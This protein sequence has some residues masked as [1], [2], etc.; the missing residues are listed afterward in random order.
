MEL[1]QRAEQL[2]SYMVEQRRWF[3]ENPERTGKEDNTI[4][5]I[6]K[7]LDKMPGIEY[8][9]VHNGGIL[10]SI[11]GGKPGKKTIL[12][13]ADV[14]ALPVEETK[15]NLKESGRTCVSKEGGVMHACGHDA[16]MAMQLGAL[17][18]LSD[19]KEEIPG[20][21]HFVFERGE[22]GGGNFIWLLKRVEELG[23]DPDSAWAIHVYADLESGKMAILDGGVMAGSGGI[24]ITIEGSGGHGSRPDQAISP[25]DCFCA[26]YQG[27]ESLRLRRITP[28]KTLTYSIGMLNAGVVGNVIPQTLSFKGSARFYDVE[29]V[30]K[31]FLADLRNLCDHT[32]AAYNCKITYNN[33]SIPGFPV[34]NDLECAQLAREALAKEIG[35]DFPVQPEPWMASESFSLYL[36]MW[37]GVFGLLGIKNPEKGTGAA[38][39]N[40]AF[41]VDED[42]LSLGAASTAA[43]TFAFLNSD[44]DTSARKHKA[45][46]KDLIMSTGRKALA[47][48]AYGTAEKK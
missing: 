32:A 8:E 25:I 40:P 48:V 35:P 33:L 30:G 7:E 21:V 27:M 44:M 43:Y 9:V 20:T 5:H 19:M 45:G 4:D 14:D 46:F 29:E 37:P 12:L 17:K 22:E 16:H 1:K 41:D 24:D 36:K 26:I 23:I 39:H 31:P 28:F 15:D 18:M 38:H 2:Q 6:A 11:K 10:G 13:R 3:H 47:E 34:I 42:V